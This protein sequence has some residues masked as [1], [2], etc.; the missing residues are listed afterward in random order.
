M[1]Y[2]ATLIRIVLR[3][4]VV[5]LIAVYLRY[6]GCRGYCMNNTFVPLDWTYV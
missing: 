4:A 3:S 1:P 2:C 6:Y 5:Y